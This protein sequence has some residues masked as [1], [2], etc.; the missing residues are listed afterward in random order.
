MVIKLHRF[1]EWIAKL[2]APQRIAALTCVAAVLV[3]FITQGPGSGDAEY[4]TSL[5]EVLLGILL[6]P[7]GLAFMAPFVAAPQLG[8]FL[9]VSRSRF[10]SLSYLM[11]AISIVLL[12]FYFLFLRSADL[13]SSST[14]GLAVPFYPLW[15][16]MYA[17]PALA[18]V[19]WIV[20]RLVRPKE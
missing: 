17:L 12:I 2:S 18:A 13:S 9:L 7:L 3:P 4:E 16:A 5:G 14:A 15:Q 19:H 10:S 8:I 6:L 20:H 11:V 1:R